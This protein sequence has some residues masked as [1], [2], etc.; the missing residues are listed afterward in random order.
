MAFETATCAL[1]EIVVK[2]NAR[3]E[4]LLEIHEQAKCVEVFQ[5]GL[6]FPSL[7]IL[8]DATTFEV[9][10]HQPSHGADM[11]PTGGTIVPGFNNSLLMIDSA[12]IAHRI[13]CKDLAASLLAPVTQAPAMLMRAA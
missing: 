12:G 3:G 5:R 1:H 10:Y 2:H 8:F 4:N 9:S 6:I 11:P 7:R 13:T